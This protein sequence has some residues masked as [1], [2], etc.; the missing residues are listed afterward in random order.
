AVDNF[1]QGGLASPVDPRTGELRKAVFKDLDATVVRYSV[2]PITG[3]RLEGFRL[4][5]WDQVINL[6]MRA[7][8]AFLEFPSVGWDVAL[9]PDGPVLVEGN[10][11]W[12][13]VLT[14][15]AS[16]EPLD[17]DYYASLLS[18]LSAADRGSV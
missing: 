17:E 2:H 4:P 7:H 1:S 9:T 16:G 14:Q 18:F 8:A 10:F 6:V 3:T 13:V 5:L 12:N 11:N 15:Q